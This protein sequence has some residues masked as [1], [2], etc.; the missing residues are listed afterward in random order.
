[1]RRDAKKEIE[2]FCFGRDSNGV[3]KACLERLVE[4]DEVFFRGGLPHWESC[5]ETLG[6]LPELSDEE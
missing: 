4:T 3:L 1:M 6:N 5:G 2:S